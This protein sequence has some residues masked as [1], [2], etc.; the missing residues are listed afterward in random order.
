LDAEFQG[1]FP[2]A[3][4]GSHIAMANVPPENAEP[5]VSSTETESAEFV[6][7]STGVDRHNVL[8]VLRANPALRTTGSQEV[9]DALL[10]LERVA[11]QRSSL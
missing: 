9:R 3:E 10:T 11:V 6:L 7:G 8:E 1:V 5:L 2:V 4:E